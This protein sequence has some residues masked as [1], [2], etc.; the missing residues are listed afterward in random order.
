MAVFQEPL[1][2]H[3]T[4]RPGLEG[5]LLAAGLRRSVAGDDSAAVGDFGSELNEGRSG[6]ADGTSAASGD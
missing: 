2:P 1:A 4:W 6:K 3:N 5:Q